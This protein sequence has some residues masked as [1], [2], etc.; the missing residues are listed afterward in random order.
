M[1]RTLLPA[2]TLW[3]RE[4]VRFLRQ[5]NRVT[6]AF[7]QPA[8]FSVLFGAGFEGSFRLA[9]PDGAPAG[10]PGQDFLEYF[11]PGTVVLILL[12]TAIFSTISIIEDRRAGFLQSVLAAPVSRG[13]RC[14]RGHVETGGSGGRR[15]GS[16]P[17][18]PSA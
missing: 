12:F 4:I 8:L 6:A 11:F 14:R 13:R 5:R 7:V 15:S 9:A 2:M 10:A 3:K 1:S 18:T 16:S 17:G